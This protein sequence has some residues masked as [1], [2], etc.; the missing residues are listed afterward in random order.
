MKK[1]LII[2]FMFIMSITL[3]SCE[4]NQ[5]QE[6]KPQEQE[7]KIVEKENNEIIKDYAPYFSHA[8][9]VNRLQIM[10][11]NNGEQYKYDA[12][13]DNGGIEVT[14]ISG[15]FEKEINDFTIS[16]DI[17]GWRPI[18][19]NVRD[20]SDPYESEIF[21]YAYVV[22]IQKEEN[23]IVGCAILELTLDDVDEYHNKF[24]RAY[25][26]ELIV[27]ISFP[28]VNGEYQEVTREYIENKLNKIKESKI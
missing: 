23:H 11:K 24:V 14:R 21:Q 16:N 7:V 25:T 6:V 18:N 8:Q 26:A 5:N 1:K 12:F 10:L 15:E 27:S 13:C 17:V 22:I 2:L 4:M 9:G 28:K 19:R 20:G 3:M